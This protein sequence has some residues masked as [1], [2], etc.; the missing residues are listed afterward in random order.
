MGRSLKKVSAD[1]FKKVPDV[2]IFGLPSM[3]Y[4]FFGGISGGWGRGDG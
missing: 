2:E 3:T 1:G 4:I